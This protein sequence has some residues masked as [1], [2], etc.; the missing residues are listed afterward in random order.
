MNEGILDT[1]VQAILDVIG[2]VPGVGEPADLVSAIISA[3]KKDWLGVA[4]RLISMSPEPASDALAKS[5]VWL[6]KAATVT[7]NRDTINA[8]IDKVGG[9]SGIETMWK[10][11]HGVVQKT[12][13]KLDDAEDS[14]IVNYARDGI[15]MIL[16]NWDD[17]NAE[18]MGALEKISDANVEAE[19]QPA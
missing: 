16:E 18:L 3:L 6:D 10:S 8:A 11:A 12:K 7:D 19:G 2:F 13:E 15:D 9:K 1:A 4:A 14:K 5:I 17:I